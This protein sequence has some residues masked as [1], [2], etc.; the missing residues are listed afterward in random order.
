MGDKKYDVV[1]INPK[2]YKENTKLHIHIP[3][4]CTLT[5]HIC[6]HIC[7]NTGQEIFFMRKS[8]LFMIQNKG[9]HDKVISIVR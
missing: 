8:F 7:L 9:F 3:C 5:I 6:T 1:I 2:N 4:M